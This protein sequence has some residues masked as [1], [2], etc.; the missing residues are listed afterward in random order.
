MRRDAGLRPKATIRRWAH[1]RWRAFIQDH[2]KRPLAEE[3]LFGKLVGGGQ[4]RVS[5][6]DD[7]SEL[8]LEC[9]ASEG[10]RN[11]FRPRQLGRGQTI[12]RPLVES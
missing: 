12:P 8:Q 9:I 4:V 10:F 2:I 6:K 1:A 7:G 5:V 11:W 3:L